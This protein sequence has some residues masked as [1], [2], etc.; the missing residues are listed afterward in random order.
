MSK[1]KPGISKFLMTTMQLR[2]PNVQFKKKNNYVFSRNSRIW[3]T[4]IWK[5]KRRMNDFEETT[6]VGNYI[7][8]HPSQYALHHL[9]NFKY[10]ELWYLTQEGCTD[11]AQHQHTQNNNTF[12]L[13]KVDDVVALRQVSMLRASKNIIPDTNLSFWQMSIAKTALI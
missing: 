7:V 9:E 4:S 12:G 2:K 8:P 5:Q 3:R 6:M 11:A 10:L 1:P 13:T